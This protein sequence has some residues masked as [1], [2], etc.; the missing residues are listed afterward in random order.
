M[1]YKVQVEVGHYNG[2][3]GE[4]LL[5]HVNSMP[6]E[7]QVPA[8]FKEK[9]LEETGQEPSYA[10][11]KMAVVRGVVSSFTGDQKFVVLSSETDDEHLI[12][13]R[14]DVEYVKVSI[15]KTLDKE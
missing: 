4:G 15:V 1:A 5:K 11:Y 10:A 9:F 14:D 8:E 2:A 13:N 7:H 12:I 3:I 6:L